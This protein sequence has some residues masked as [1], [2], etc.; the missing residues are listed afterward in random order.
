MERLTETA[1]FTIP[2]DTFCRCQLCGYEKNDI[3]EFRFWRECDENDKP[4]PY[5]ILITCRKSTCYETIGAHPRLYRELQWSTGQPG[6]FSLICGECPHREGTRCIHPKLHANGGEGLTVYRDNSLAFTVCYH[7]EADPSGGLSCAHHG[8][9][10]TACE[11]LP[12]DHYRY[13][14]A[15]AEKQQSDA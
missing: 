5:R 6:H 7:N 2:P 9:P 1:P 14:A 3:C 13:R 15:P 4:E 10:M 11:G 12:E 8:G